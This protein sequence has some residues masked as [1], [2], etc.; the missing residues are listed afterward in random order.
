[1]KKDYSMAVI[2][3]AD[4]NAARE[5]KM[6]MVGLRY[7]IASII[8]DEDLDAFIDDYSDET[9]WVGGNRSDVEEACRFLPLAYI[10]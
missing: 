6:D 3:L 1:M 4:V 10:D 7:H 5:D 8:C 2:N 9:I